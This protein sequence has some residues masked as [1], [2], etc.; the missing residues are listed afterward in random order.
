MSRAAARSTII[1]VARAAGVSVSTVSR[2]ING[3]G[4][5]SEKTALAVRGA[6]TEVGFTA[7]PVAR[8]LVG[9]RTRLIGL[10]AR[11]I[12]DDYVSSVLRGVARAVEEAGYGLLLFGGSAGDENPA[13]GLVTTLPDGLLV[14]SPGLDEEPD[15]WPDDRPV[16]FVEPRSAGVPGVMADN[17]T[18]AAAAIEHLLALGHCRIGIVRGRPE[19]SSSR[20][21]LAGYEAALAW[22]GIPIDPDLIAPG[23]ND[24][25]SGLAAGRQLLALADPPTAI[26]ATN[27][28]EA[29]GVLTAA[30]DLGI[31]V[32]NG[33]SVVGFDD[34]PPAQHTVPALTTI[35][36]PLAEM[37]RRA[38][39]MLLDWIAGTP[40]ADQPDG[41]L[42]MLPTHL[43]IRDSAGPAPA[44]LAAVDGGRGLSP[45]AVT[46]LDAGRRA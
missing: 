9:A 23:N 16:V 22:A 45:S 33:L 15:R 25:D 6:M 28:L 18:G 36:Q 37:G 2:V 41:A 5:V 1:D 44:S 43:V 38:V 12:G 21:R 40:P 46:R 14:I 39:A 27:D 24:R 10:H 7:S 29:V 4:E 17:V 30:R 19:L 42:V 34:Q 20:D 35:H 11:N 31:P 3:K 32:P 26:F 13:A 8:S